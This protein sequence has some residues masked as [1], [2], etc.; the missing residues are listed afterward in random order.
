MKNTAAAPVVRAGASPN[1]AMEDR[2]VQLP[3]PL[4]VHGSIVP[5]AVRPPPSEPSQ[6]LGR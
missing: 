5:C 4:P 2:R 3:D 1:A 6:A